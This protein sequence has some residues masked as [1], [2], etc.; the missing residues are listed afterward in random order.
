MSSRFPAVILILCLLP[1]SL[2]AQWQSAGAVSSWK[3]T[4]A[5]L[6]LQLP[7]AA[8][9]IQIVTPAVVRV[10]FSPTGR[11]TSD[12]SWAVIGRPG[13]PEFRAE[14]TPTH[15]R[16]LTG[17]LR[18]DIGKSPCRL[19]VST[20]DGTFLFADDTLRGTGWSGSAVTVWKQISAGEHFYGLGEKSN[21]FEKSGSALS[22]WNSDIPAYSENTDPLYQDIPFYYAIRDSLSY[23]VFLDNP[24]FSHFIFGK[25]DRSLASFGVSGGDLNYYLIYGPSPREVLRRFTDLTGRM[26]LPPL[27]SLGYQQ[28]RWSYYPER[29]VREIASTFRS[30]KIPCDAIYLDIH[31]MDGYRVFTWDTARF[32]SPSAMVADLKKDGFKTVVIIDP[33]IKADSSYSAYRDGER[34]RVFV[35]NA[36]GSEFIGK[37]WPGDCVFP[38]FTRASA[39]SWWGSLY[40]GL[41]AAGVRGFWNDM[42]EPSVFDGP[43]KTFP[44]NAR[45]D[46]HGIPSDHAATHNVYGMQMVR[47]TY[48][49]VRRL[50]PDERPFVLTRAN[51]AGGQRYSAAWTGDNVSSWEHLRLG[52]RICLGMSICGQPFTGTDIGGFIGMPTGEL[53]ARW[54]EFGVFSPLMRSHAEINSPNKEPWEYGPDFEAVNRKTIELRYQLLPYI[55]SA[56]R[57]SA[58]TG[59]AIMRPLVFDYPADPRTALCDDE[60]MFGI[61]LL[62][63]PVTEP[64]QSART[65]YLPAGTWYD[66]HTGNRTAGGAEV[67]SAAPIG[68]IPV[69]VKAGT[70]VPTQPA[71]QYVGEKPPDRI[72]LTVYPDRGTAEGALYEDDGIS[73]DYMNGNYAER[74][75]HLGSGAASDTL[76]LSEPSGTYTPPPRLLEFRILGRDS[77]PPSVRRGSSPFRQ[78]TGRSAGEE[79]W[80]FRPAEHELILRVRDSFRHEV[81]LI[82]R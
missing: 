28:C 57:N 25:E 50:R 27:W 70:I 81:F 1:A 26:H 64:G 73:F 74:T 48:E 41:I 9:E 3:K 82:G 43:Q 80:E 53:Y 62:A 6:I 79:G 72:T 37:V 22:M 55:Y 68:R 12:S 24:S 59:D 18:L 56:F 51:Y 77:V 75:V 11:F 76:A 20:A 33:G 19:S 16:I 14:E 21:A 10:R 52:I 2:N 39:R 60:F 40:E 63:A 65:V 4:A 54:L 78:M 61:A 29:R 67:T 23:G 31:Y 69:F 34:N 58:E 47:A 36:D 49:G 30:K 66:F 46:D 8:L 32:P 35:Q 71:E 44:L 7:P 17:D 45:A 5:G 13:T 15:I 38:D 42:N